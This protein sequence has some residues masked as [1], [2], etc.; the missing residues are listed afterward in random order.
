MQYGQHAGRT[1][2][3][4]TAMS[5]RQEGHSAGCEIGRPRHL[6]TSLSADAE[7]CLPTSD[8]AAEL[9]EN[10]VAQVSRY[11]DRHRGA[12]PRADMR[13]SWSPSVAGYDAVRK[14]NRLELVGGSGELSSRTLDETTI[15]IR[16][17]RCAA[18]R[19]KSTSQT[20]CRVTIERRMNDRGD[21]RHQSRHVRVLEGRCQNADCRRF[22][23]RGSAAMPFV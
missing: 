5:I 14:M 4:G 18:L 9:M 1:L 3:G 10:A 15:R 12:C 2:F 11:L 17:R 22:A 16:G 8:S 23:E 19:E 7:L 6:G 20:G 21:R 13:F